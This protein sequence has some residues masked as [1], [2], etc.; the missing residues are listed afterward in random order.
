MTNV[1]E[2]FRKMNAQRQ[3]NILKSF[4][5]D[6]EK[7]QETSQKEFSEEQQRIIKGLSSENPFERAAA[8]EELNKSEMSDI[9]KSDIMDAISYSNEFKF[10]KTGKEIIEKVKNVI[11]PKKNAELEAKK[12]EA[13]KLLSDCGNAPTASVCRYWLNS[14]NLDCG[15]K[16]YEWHECRQ[17]SKAEIYDSLSWEHQEQQPKA[18]CPKTEDEARV[19]C[20][21]NDAVEIIC[22]I[23]I[24]IKAC[25]ILINNLK[26]NETIKMTPQQLCVFGFE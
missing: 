20:K 7:A 5:V 18:K 22:R 10:S 3:I 23:M 11:L 14:F 17:E 12:A 4:G 15:Y 13:D 19:R 26:E 16:L 1:T 21:Y 2:T 9:E 25:Q 6:F 8:E 24:D